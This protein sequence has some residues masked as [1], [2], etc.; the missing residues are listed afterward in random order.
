MIR[1]H[2][3]AA[4][5]TLV[6]SIAAGAAASAWLADD[7]RAATADGE[8]ARER[9][10]MIAEVTRERAHELLARWEE[11]HVDERERAEEDLL[12]MLAMHEER[13]ADFESVISQTADA[14]A[15]SERVLADPA[16]RAER[17]VRILA[18]RILRD[19]LELG[20]AKLAS[21]DPAL[22]AEGVR[23][24]GRAARDGNA[25]ALA[26]LTDLLGDPEEQV[27][28]AALRELIALARRA[29]DGDALR[30]AMNAAGVDAELAAMLAVTDGRVRRQVLRALAD[31]QSPRATDGWLALYAED[32]GWRQ[33]AEAARE[34]RELG[35][36]GPHQDMIGAARAGLTSD[37]RRARRE[38]IQTLVALG[39]DDALAIL[40]NALAADPGGP[41]ARALERSLTM[42]RRR[43]QVE[44]SDDEQA[45]P[46]LGPI[47]RSSRSGR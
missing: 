43:S 12:D 44:E 22:R 11:E 31:L 29:Q 36:T 23:D 18:A 13:L 3:I 1:L 16:N 46:S 2:P 30:A 17:D 20:L 10:E 26:L 38:A 8:A 45:E 21:G 41:D 4:G 42:L 33:K 35:T 24:V 37:D 34:L 39:G 40:E 28:Q 47:R 9:A 32:G 19:P 27:G 6:L 7:G 25:E 5:V 15:L 14:V